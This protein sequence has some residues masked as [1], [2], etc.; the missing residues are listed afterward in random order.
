MKTHIW[1][2]FGQT[3][4]SAAQSDGYVGLSTMA[5]ICD[6]IEV[7]LRQLFPAAAAKLTKA[8]DLLA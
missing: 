7:Y 5:D 6:E 1:S 3:G 8:G 2:G 4:C